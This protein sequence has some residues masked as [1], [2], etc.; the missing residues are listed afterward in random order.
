MI[1]DRVTVLCVLA[2]MIGGGAIAW[3]DRRTDRRHAETDAKATRARDDR[4][5]VLSAMA[6]AR[7]ARSDA[8]RELAKERLR[9]LAER[10]VD[11]SGGEWVVACP[12]VALSR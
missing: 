1:A 10:G 8:E 11:L 4:R 12:R 6:A 2:G 9:R 3:N 5:E 7:D